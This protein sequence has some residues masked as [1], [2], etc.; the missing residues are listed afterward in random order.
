MNIGGFEFRNPLKG[1][2]RLQP[3]MTKKCFK[4]LCMIINS[5]HSKCSSSAGIMLEKVVNLQLSFD[6]IITQWVKTQYINEH[7]E[8][9]IADIDML[10]TLFPSACKL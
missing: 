7:V 10:H 6:E 2:L 4:Q 9:F 5:K 8:L 1:L 3:E